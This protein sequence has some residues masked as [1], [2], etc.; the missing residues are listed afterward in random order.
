MVGTPALLT[1]IV[2]AAFFAGAFVA[3]VLNNQ[4]LGT[5]GK[6]PDGAGMIPQAA[7]KGDRIAEPAPS[8]ERASVSAVELVGVSHAIVILRDASGAVLYRSDPQ[9]GTTILAK[10]TELPVVTLKEQAKGPATQ[11]P[12]IRKEGNEA[13]LPAP[14]KPSRDFVG[15]VGDVS[16]LVSA[17][18]RRGPS[19]CLAQSERFLF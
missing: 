11:H 17:S 1:G 6:F 5:P 9:A 7:A 8:R 19:L 14:S 15:C 4:P 3:D 2:G 13:P 10:N 16:S 12:V 18:A